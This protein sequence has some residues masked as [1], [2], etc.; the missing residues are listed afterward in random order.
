MNWIG[1]KEKDV[2]TKELKNIGHTLWVLLSLNGGFQGN[3]F[4]FSV[5]S[6]SSLTLTHLVHFRWNPGSYKVL[7]RDSFGTQPSIK[8]MLHEP[9]FNADF[10]RRFLI[11][12]TR[13]NF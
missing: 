11:H 2:Q 10:Q 13:D 12:V 8:V 6:F 1:N 9:I 7:F 3:I 5:L 4:T